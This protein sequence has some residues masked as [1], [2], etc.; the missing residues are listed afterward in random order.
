MPHE[1]EEIIILKADV[2]KKIIPIVNWFN[3]QYGVVTLW[4]CQGDDKILTGK[5]DLPYIQFFCHNNLVFVPRVKKMIADIGQELIN[6]ESI[7]FCTTIKYDKFGPM[8]AY[9]IHMSG[10]SVLEK[11]IRLIE[12]ME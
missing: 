12:E 10:P 3:K 9:E 8:T 4:S 11:M 5:V 6:D 2:D 1:T 7:N